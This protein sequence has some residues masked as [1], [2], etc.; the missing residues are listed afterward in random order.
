MKPDVDYL[1]EVRGV[2]DGWSIAVM[3][4]GSYVNRWED[5]DNP[6]CAVP[7]FESRFE[8]I[9]AALEEGRGTS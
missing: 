4:D 6:G 9:R 3:K 8:K 7:G 5:P 2:Y 1:V